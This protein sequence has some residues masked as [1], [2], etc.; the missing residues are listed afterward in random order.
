MFR[1]SMMAAVFCL[2]ALSGCAAAKVTP[3]PGAVDPANPVASTPAFSRQQLQLREDAFDR[4][5]LSTEPETIP[6]SS[7]VPGV[8]EEQPTPAHHQPA[9]DTLDA[10]P[11]TGKAPSPGTVAAPRREP[12]PPIYVCPMH[13]DI[14][15]ATASKCS[16]CG[17]TLVRQK[18][19]Q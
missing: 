2:A 14:T 3:R 19:K 17:M 6:D 1:P 9:E 11:A 13:P 16:K 15:G 4:V 7:V 5:V 18:E 12:P 10:T 8:S